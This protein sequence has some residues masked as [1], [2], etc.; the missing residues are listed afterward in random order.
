MCKDPYRLYWLLS[1]QIYLILFDGH[2]K[3]IEVHITTLYVI[4]EK[5]RS[6]CDIPIILGD[7]PIILVIDNE[8]N[9]ASVKF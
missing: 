2:L 3:W 4:V 8:N 5:M 1:R 6:T 9:F 7:I